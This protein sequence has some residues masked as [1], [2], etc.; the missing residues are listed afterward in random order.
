MTDDKSGPSAGPRPSALGVF[1]PLISA[2]DL[3]AAA[4]MRGWAV[5]FEKRWCCD[6]PCLSPRTEREAAAVFWRVPWRGCV[7]GGGGMHEVVGGVGVRG[8]R[9]GGV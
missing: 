2:R 7:C 9:G 5:A 8:V 3:G 4:K 6:W 1:W